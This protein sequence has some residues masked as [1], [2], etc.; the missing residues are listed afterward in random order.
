MKRTVA[1]FLLVIMPFISI[2]TVWDLHYCGGILRSV[3]LADGK[4][5]CCCGIKGEQSH[6][7]DSPQISQSCCSD[8]LLNIATDDFDLSNSVIGTVQTVSNPFLLHDN[9]LKLSEPYNFSV[10]QYLF[11]PGGFAKYNADLLTLI[12]IFRI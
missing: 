1:V 7:Q 8:Y 10:L 5:G 2:Q 12:C 4:S 3:T 9:P 11:P 6:A